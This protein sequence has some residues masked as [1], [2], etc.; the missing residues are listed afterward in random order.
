LADPDDDV[1][2]ACAVMAEAQV[3][4]SGDHH[5]LEMKTYQQIDILPA[6]HFMVHFTQNK[7]NG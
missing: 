1:I 7:A 2:L 3:I 6:S 5:L 4:V